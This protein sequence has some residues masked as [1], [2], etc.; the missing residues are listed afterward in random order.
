MIRIK[1]EDRAAQCEVCNAKFG[2]ITEKGSVK[3]HSRNRCNPCYQKMYLDENYISTK[4]KKGDA[5]SC[6]ECKY[7]YNSRNEKGKVVRKGS[8]GHCKRCYNRLFTQKSS[9][10]CKGCGNEM[11]SKRL[12]LCAI[13][14]QNESTSKKWKRKQIKPQIVN[15][16]TFELIRR[17]LARYKSAHNDF[18]DA[19][20]VIDVYMDVA[21]TNLLDNLR[22]EQQVIEMLRWLKVTFDYNLEL[23]NKRRESE[24]KRR[25]LERLKVERKIKYFKKELKY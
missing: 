12:S 24:A 14:K 2:G 10:I 19:F 7:E 13:C 6:I 18:S 9:N 21:D 25:E 22:E 23:L 16:E 1:K 17:L 4:H 8:R 5:T 11:I 15:D 20:R 3:Y